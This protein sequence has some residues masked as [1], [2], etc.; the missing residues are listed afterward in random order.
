MPLSVPLLE[1]Q[2]T[3]EPL[4][5]AANVDQRG[6]GQTQLHSSLLWLRVSLLSSATTSLLGLVSHRPASGL[7]LYR[8]Y[9]RCFNCL[10]GSP[11]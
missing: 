4:V 10:A 11:S 2:T 7:D 5:S 3:K 9:C 8:L 6:S 1:T